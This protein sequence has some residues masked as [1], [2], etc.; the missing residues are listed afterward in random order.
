MAMELP[1][2]AIAYHYEPLLVPAGEHWTPAAEMR[3]KHFLH[4]DRL[5]D[6]VPRLMQCRSRVAAEREMRVVPP[7]MEPLEPGF[8]DLPQS[9]LD[10]HRR[11]GDD[12]D[13]GRLLALA[14]RLRDD[15]DRIVVLG[16]GGAAPSARALFAALRNVYHN[17]L[18]GEARLGVPCVYFEGDSADNET[19]QDLLELLQITCVDPERREE[20]WAVVAVNKTGNTLEPAVALRVFRREAA[21]FYGLRSQWLTRL[22]SAVTA[23]DS[24]L[25]ASFAAAG[26]DSDD[27]LHLP[28]N[29]G[30]RYSVFTAAGLLPAALMGLDVRALLLGA[31]AMTKRFVEEPFDRNPVLQFAGVNHLLAEQCGKPVRVLA[32]WSKKLEAVGHWYEQLVSESLGKLGHGPTAMTMVGTRDLHGRGQILLEGPRDRVV[33][34]LVVKGQ[35]SVPVLVQMSDHNEDGLNAISRKGIPDLTA[36]AL[37]GA[38]QAYF[39]VGRPTADLLVPS[40]S[41]H[42]LGQL[43]QMLMLATV[44]EGRLMGINPYSHGAEDLYAHHLLDH[45]QHQ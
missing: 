42:T 2:E 25:Q 44:V 32:V 43:M 16:T 15:A 36:A 29:V 41:E 4:P 34:N 3:A 17:E 35:R 31:A 24:S 26:H 21:E 18:P 40:L 6:I 8:I 1:D 12:S 27:V 33:N 14:N 30:P 9:T 37:R 39:D 45:L 7:D 22:F 28:A 20:R 13:L 19:L 38:N 23:A 5:R 10:N 11:K